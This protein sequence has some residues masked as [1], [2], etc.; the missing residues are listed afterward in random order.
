VLGPR[1]TCARVE[2]NGVQDFDETGVDVL[3]FDVTVEGFQPPS[4]PYNPVAT[5]TN[6]VPATGN[7]VYTSSGDPIH[8]GDAIVIENERIRV[9]AVNI[10]TNTLT[11]Q[12]GYGNTT[13]AAHTAGTEILRGDGAIGWFIGLGHDDSVF[14]ID[15]QDFNFFISMFAGST[16][17]DVGIDTTEGDDRV[18]LSV[19]DTGPRASVEA[20]SGV[21]SRVPIRVDS[22]A[23]T[24]LYPL[25]LIEVAL[26][27]ASSSFPNQPATLNSA[28]IA[29]GVNCP[30]S[31]GDGVCDP[32]TTSTQCIGFDSCQ[33]TPTGSAVDENGCSQAQ[34]DYDLDGHCNPGNYSTLCSGV[35]NC[36]SHSNSSQTNTDVIVNP[37]GDSQGDA[38]DS[39][40]DN[41]GVLDSPDNCDLA[42]NPDQEDFNLDG[43][44]DACGDADA[45]GV[46]DAADNCRA[47]ANSDQGDADGDGA[48]NA[49]D[50]DDDNDLVSDSNEASCG[51]NPIDGGSVPERID[52]IFAGQDDDKDGSTDEFLPGPAQFYDCDGDGYPGTVENYLY[53]PSTRGD[54]DPCGTN[55]DSPGVPP[56]PIGWP[57]DLRGAGVPE[58]TNRITIRDITSYLAPT[59]H[60]G[61]NVGATAGNVRWD[62]VPGKGVLSTDIN[63]QDIL[64]ILAIEPPMLSGRKAFAGPACPWGD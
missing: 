52:S 34:V 22:G 41:D 2:P 38:C 12:R 1:D 60:L 49:C 14:T 18:D 3:H 39:D 27:D 42:P 37:P 47:D 54:Q 7:I 26:F 31:D 61:A 11:V 63:I 36:P 46:I 24:G 5:L 28:E 21:L 20:G 16:P 53:S 43:Q 8:N 56:T 64:S 40:D 51:S 59:R 15:S 45:D 33:E 6:A 44:G 19:A 30:D 23:A 57:A 29:V 58:S 13:A 17:L 50:S 32:G 9:T 35:D 55:S 62:I 10:T 48:G 4:T 25:T